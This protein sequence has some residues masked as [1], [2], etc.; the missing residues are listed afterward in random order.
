MKTLYFDCSMGAAGDMLTASLLELVPDP[1]AFVGELNSLGIPH[2]RFQ[3]APVSKCGI[4]GTHMAVLIDGAEEG[5]ADAQGHDH[6]D[7]DHGHEHHHAEEHAHDHEDSHGNP[8]VHHHEHR[9]LASV[10]EI[11]AS[12]KVSQ[13]VK[14]D[15]LA[16]YR[17]IAEAESSVHGRP[18]SEVHF[19]E[20]GTLDAIADVA[21]VCLLMERI[22]PEAVYASPVHVGS[23]TVNCAHGILPVPAPA[24][25]ILL[26]GIPTYGG[27]IR[28]E[29]CTPTGAALL[30]HFVNSFGEMPMMRTEAIGYGMGRKDFPQ[31]NCI[32][33]FLGEAENDLTDSVIRL[34][35]NLDDMTAEE[36]GFATERLFEEGAAEVFTSSVLMKKN[37]PGTLL[38]VLC[39]PEKKE[40]IVRALFVHTSTIGIRESVVQRYILKR[41]IEAAET[42]LGTVHVKRSEGYGVTKAKIEYEDLAEIARREKISL[43]EARRRAE[44]ESVSIWAGQ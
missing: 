1:D 2:V 33:A 21:A 43:A 25:A 38:T 11:T 12:L 37:R 35:I 5:E 10:E 17:L 22:A 26:K 6:H 13:K 28:G 23:G 32:R 39:R 29:L 40:A 3:K 15:I 19:H 36:I 42:S 4:R 27:A 34:E 9:S 16:V 18:V 14:E 24:T 31:A 41:Q 44:S 20:V 8:H 7:H 30:K